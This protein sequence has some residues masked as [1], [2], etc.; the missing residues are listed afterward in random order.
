MTRLLFGNEMSSVMKREA[1]L[2]IP[3]YDQ[4]SIT[5]EDAQSD[6]LLYLLFSN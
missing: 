5:N 4:Q 2:Y 6:Q 1:E 3:W